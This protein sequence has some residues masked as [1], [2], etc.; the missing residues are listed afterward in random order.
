MNIIKVFIL[1]IFFLSITGFKRHPH[2]DYDMGDEFRENPVQEGLEDFFNGIFNQLGIGNVTDVMN[3][4]DITTAAI[5]YQFFTLWSSAIS[6]AGVSNAPLATLQ[7]FNTTGG[8]LYQ[9]FPLSLLNCRRNS[10]DYNKLTNAL[11]M[12]IAETIF[13]DNMSNY[14][15][16]QT[17]AYYSQFKN[18]SNLFITVQPYAAGTVFGSFLLTV[19]QGESSVY[20]KDN[21][22]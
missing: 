3:C 15:F 11:G 1:S 13:L 7:Y 5:Q 8:K 19:S 21:E 17:E 16:N 12:D 18:M 10:E 14:L 2:L 20:H 22:L 9:E 4:Y 6:L